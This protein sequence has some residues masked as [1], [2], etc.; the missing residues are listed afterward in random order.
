MIRLIRFAVGFGFW[1]VATAGRVNAM[2]VTQLRCEDRADAV[3]IDVTRPRLGWALHSDTRADRQTAYQILVASSATRL[4]EDNGDL[5]D[6]GRVESADTIGIAYAGLPLTTG[7]QAFWKVRAWD[8]DGRPSAWS[9]PSTWTTGVADSADWASAQWITA[10]K[11][12]A[13]LL[14]RRAFTVRPGLR[15]AV[16]FVSGLGHYEMTLNGRPVTQDVLTPGWTKYDRTVLYDTYD[17]TAALRPGPNAAGLMLGNGMYH[18]AKTKGRYTKF[19]KSFGPQK[20]IAQFYLTYDDGTSDVIG[21]D[22]KWRTAAG[23]ITF[24]SVF[25]GEDY[26]ARRHEDDWDTPAFDDAAWPAAVVTTGPGGTLRGLS[27]A[28]P[29]V[30]VIDTLKPAAVRTIRPGVAVYD[31]GQNASQM[32]AMT[33]KG[34]AGSSVRLLPAELLKPD[35]TVDQHSIGQPAFCVYTLAGGGPE[36]WS[37]R[38]YYCGYRYLQVETTAAPDGGARPVVEAI[39]SRIVHTSSPQAGAFTSSSD[40][41]NRAYT[42]VRWAQRSNMVSVLTD[43]PHREKL[44]WLEQIHL[45]G[46]ALR[47]NFDLNAFFTKTMNDMA[48][49]QLPSGLI[50][51]TAPEYPV[52]GEK[53]RDSPEW[54]SAVLVVAWQQYQFT[55]DASLLRRHYAGMK[56]Y[57]AYLGTRAKDHIVRH[58]LS[59]WYDIGP[60][61][62]GD[63]KLTPHGVTA[64]A[65]YYYDA[66]VLSKIARLLDKP[67]EAAEYER[68]AGEIRT[69]FN[70][71]FFNASTGQYATGS[72]CANAMPLAL[73][74]T[75][76]AARDAVLRHLVDDV[77]KKGLTAGDI[78]YKYLLNALAEGGRSDVVFAMINQSDKPGYGLQLARGATSL[79]EAWDANPRSS[80]NHFMLGQ[81]NEWFFGDLAGI[82]QDPA[83]PG[84]KHVLIRPAIVG[85]LTHA[86]ATY[87]SVRGPITS[88]WTRAG[89][90]VTL[91]V[92]LP[93]NTTATVHVPATDALAVTESGRPTAEA[94]GVKLVHVGKNSV[95]YAVGSGTYTFVGNVP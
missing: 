95:V 56:R 48:D 93:A 3:G 86:K 18:V 5:W 80:Q 82:R 41:F 65:F 89:S 71:T 13:S 79:T 92:T 14:L 33:V 91:T 6:S 78:G 58:G 25:G 20:A 32:P 35:G 12:P 63:S 51:T 77:N 81:I 53:F 62:P 9:T 69:A 22:D 85:D 28:A 45:N 67:D 47:Y 30:R 64:T 46:S 34:P 36:T 21:T 54:G 94:E 24:T 50:P 16:V 8:K 52:F 73:G 74:I 87:Q 76:S 44:G 70:A 26:D 88:V 4:D 61:D 57:V 10:A 72:Q 84:F 17:V 23:P 1:L 38:F 37:P 49:S 7:Q 2:D 59:D 40:L 29:P 39:E 15:R 55:G 31:F 68:L 75:D 42:L 60:G 11:P 19:E 66:V 43:C 83:A 27:A 90:R